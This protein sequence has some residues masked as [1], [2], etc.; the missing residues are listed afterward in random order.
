[1]FGRKPQSLSA[2]QGGSRKGPP[3]KRCYAIGDVHG[4]LD[5]LEGLFDIIRDHNK[6]RPKRQTTIVMLGDL[7]DRGPDSRGV[8]EFLRRPPEVGANLVCLKG[9][10]EE[11]LLQGLSGNPDTLRKWVALGGDQCVKSYG[12]EPGSLLG[13]PADQVESILAAHIPLDHIEFL[14]SFSDSARFGDF[15][16]VHAGIR[17]GL[18]LN[19]QS[20]RDL[21]WIRKEFLTSDA[22]HE[23]LVV[24]GHSV[25]VDIEQR[26]NRIGIDTGAYRSGLLTA[27]CIEDDQTEFVQ[28]QGAADPSFESA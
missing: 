7:I 28:Y 8:I 20:P 4:R 2:V 24:H 23:F 13:Q 18:P 14:E 16:L 21:R 3:G 19:E 17:P 12:I 1:M 15:L 6:S 22:Q 9:N 10:H 26:E 5:L 27:V 25:T 11:M